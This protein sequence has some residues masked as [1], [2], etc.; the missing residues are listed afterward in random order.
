MTPEQAAFGLLS[1]ASEMDDILKGAMG[2][3]VEL[4]RDDA[5][6]RIGVQQPGWA[7]LAPATEERKARGGYPSGAP[8]LREGELRDSIFGQVVGQDG[9]VGSNDEAAAPQEFGTATIP[10]RPFI[11]PAIY[12]NHDKI[13][14]IIGK[15]VVK[16]IGL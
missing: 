10:P 7:P 11:G 13:A 6:S 15:H 16:K 8:L 12:D 9:Y 1:A 4:V 3:A 2:E 14:D 5:K